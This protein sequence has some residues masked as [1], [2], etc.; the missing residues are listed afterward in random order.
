MRRALPARLPSGAS[1]SAFRSLARRASGHHSTF[2]RKG[3]HPRFGLVFL[4]LSA[5]ESRRLLTLPFIPLAGYRSGLSP[6]LWS[7]TPLAHFCDVVRANPFPLSHVSVTR[8][9]SPEVSSTACDAQ[10]PDITPVSWMDMGFAML[11]SLARHR[12]PPI[13]FLFLGSRL[14]STLLS[15]PASRRVLFHPCASL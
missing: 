15:G 10:P 7:I 13:R 1:P 14:C 2:R 4:P 8:R 9:R 3:Q 6:M 5:P 12:R 11:G